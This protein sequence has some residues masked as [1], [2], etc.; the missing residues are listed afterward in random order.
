MA[1]SESW[2]ILVLSIP[3]GSSP[4]RFEWGAFGPDFLV[5][6]ARRE[7]R[8]STCVGGHSVEYIERCHT[9]FEVTDPLQDHLVLGFRDDWHDITTTTCSK[10]IFKNSS[11]SALANKI[12][13]ATQSAVVLPLV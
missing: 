12:F 9:V 11:E 1:R 2:F 4:C 10:Y 8:E 7:N 13:Y 5:G 6:C 3:S